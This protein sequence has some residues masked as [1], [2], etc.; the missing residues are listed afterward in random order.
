MHVYVVLSRSDTVLS[1]LIGAVTGDEYTHAA[2]ALDPGLGLMFSFGRRRA[3][4]PFVGCFKRER[5]DDDVYGR[6]RELPGVVLAVPVTPAQREAVCGQLAQ[7][8][9]DSH[10]YRYNTAG[11]V[12]ALV[13]RGSEDDTRFFCSEFVYHVLHRA[14]VCDLGVPRRLVHPQTLLGVPGEVLFEGDL[15]AYAAAAAPAERG[16][17]LTF[18]R[19]RVRMA[20]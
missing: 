17:S 1:R 2:L 12:S 7:F 14:G 8:L 6:A 3:G 13:G 18:D 11:L 10:A 16:A 20:A 15:K 4:N 5:L 19:T 9:L